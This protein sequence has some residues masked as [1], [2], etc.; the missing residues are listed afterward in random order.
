VWRTRETIVE[1]RRGN[2]VE[3]P[4]GNAVQNP[5]GNA[6][7]N[8]RGNAV[9]NPRGNG[10]ENPHGNAVQN[11]RGN[12]V[13]NPENDRGELVGTP[14]TSVERR[15]HGWRSIEIDS[16]DVCPSNVVGSLL[17]VG[18]DQHAGMAV[19]EIAGAIE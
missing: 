1:N 11:P 16:R 9:E 17:A 10:V 2:G 6:V 5:R 4:R 18:E 7:Q 13:E 14:L 3:N 15:V 19:A 8:P 12:A